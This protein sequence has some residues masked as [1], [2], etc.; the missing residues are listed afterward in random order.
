YSNSTQLATFIIGSY[1]Y[2]LYLHPLRKFPG[3]WTHR[4]SRIPW[5]YHSLRGDL[6]EHLLQLQRRYAASTLLISLST[7]TR[8]GVVVSAATDNYLTFDVLGQLAFSSDFQCLERSELHP[9]ISSMFSDSLFGPVCLSVLV[10]FGFQVAV[11]LLYKQ[12]GA[13]F[14]RLR[15]SARLKVYDRLDSEK[16]Q[17][18]F[19]EVL[20]R[21]LA[22]DTGT[23]AIL[24]TG[25]TLIFAGSETQATLLYGLTYL[26]TRNLT[27]LQ[28]LTEEVRGAFATQEGITYT[29]VSRLRYLVACINEGL[30]YFPSVANA[31]TK[32][33]PAGGCVIN[34]DF[35]PGGT[36][37]GIYHYAMYHNAVYFKNPDEFHPER[38][39]GDPEYANDRRELFQPFAIGPR[40]CL[41]K[42]LAHAEIRMVLATM[43]LNFDLELW[44]DNPSLLKEMRAYG[45]FWSKPDLNLRLKPVNG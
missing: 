45:V 15:Q 35:V 36:I 23:E 24:M 19:T 39:L 38:W 25:P 31:S 40:D 13:R 33:S 3:P 43:V 32:R 30:R 7:P 29:D 11:D 42:M 26:L 44:E 8:P 37:S 12:L 2:N 17:D 5:A 27:A 41:G 10:N 9:W 20:L 4:A 14:R 1:I 16:P 18:D 28:K 22:K 21:K 6:N 34:G